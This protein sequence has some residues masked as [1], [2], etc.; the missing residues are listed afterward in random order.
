MRLGALLP[1]GGLLRGEA[2]QEALGERLAAALPVGGVLFLEGQLGAGKTTLVRGL[3]R[4][5]GFAGGVSSPTYALMHRYPTP[6]G[7]LLHI[8]AYRIA[9]AAELWEMDLEE[10]VRAS[11]LTAMEWGDA[12][13]ADFPQAFCLRLEHL[14][15]R[16]GVRRVSLRSTR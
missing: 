8:D 9:D 2:E 5:L 6:A 10:E 4:G 1:E 14:P 11:R 3:A 15:D 12:F 16:P 7:P 13:Y